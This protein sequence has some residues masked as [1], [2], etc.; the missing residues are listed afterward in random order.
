[1]VRVI[2]KRTQHN[3]DRRTFL[4]TATFVVRNRNNA[5]DV[6]ILVAIVER[7]FRDGRDLHRLVTGAHTRRHDQDVVACCDASVRTSIT[8]ERPAFVDWKIIGRSSVQVFRQFA[9]DGNVVSH[10]VMGDLFALLD[11]ERCSDWLTKLKY[12]LARTDITRRKAMTRR[13]LAAD[14]N[15]RFIWQQ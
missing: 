11:S 14:L 15:H 13:N 2:R 3:V 5:I 7:E 6:W 10:V 4:T 1:M 12:K 8:H 9:H